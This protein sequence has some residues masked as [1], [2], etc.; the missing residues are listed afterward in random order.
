MAQERSKEAK[1]YTFVAGILMVSLL[2]FG[3]LSNFGVFR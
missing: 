2:T 3:V 1:I